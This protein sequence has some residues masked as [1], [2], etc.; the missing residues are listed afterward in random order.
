VPT[1]NLR[2]ETTATL[3]GASLLAALVFWLRLA[4]DNP[5]DAIL[6]LLLLPIGIVAMRFG[7]IGGVCSAA[8]SL[9]LFAIWDHTCDAPLGP[10]GY[11]T[12]AVVFSGIGVTIGL[13]AVERRKDAERGPIGAHRLDR[14]GFL[15]PGAA[16]ERGAEVVGFSA[17]DR[18][19]LRL[20]DGQELEVPLVGAI[21]D[22]VDV[23]S[24]TLVF[25]DR[26]GRALGW[27]LPDVGLGVDMRRWEKPVE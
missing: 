25:F 2:T 24:S 19:V 26:E 1:L 4:D 14:R 6:V 18:A 17:S 7:W 12:S 23:G 9:L 15:Q 13:L 8:A 3:V 20:D 10:L 27:Y 11:L 5:C 16:N 21:R 22:S